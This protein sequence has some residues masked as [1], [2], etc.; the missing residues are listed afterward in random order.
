MTN[1]LVPFYVYPDLSA[2]NSQWQKLA[3]LAIAYPK[4]EIWAVINVNSGPGAKTDPNYTNGLRVLQQSGVKLLGYVDTT[5]AKRQIN[6]VIADNGMW[7][8]WYSATKLD[9]FFY[10]NVE[11][12]VSQEYYWSITSDIRSA[13]LKAFGNPGTSISESYIGIF[14]TVVIYEGTG[15]SPTPNPFPEPPGTPAGYDPKNFAYLIYGQP[16]FAG[17]YIGDYGFVYVTSGKLPDPYSGIPYLQQ[18]LAALEQ[19]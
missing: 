10:D 5:R 14:D 3:Q 7:M 15:L 9:G 13:G 11:N 2:P 1:V 16:K 12:T 18:L 6:A 19:S 8:S 4:T 17:P